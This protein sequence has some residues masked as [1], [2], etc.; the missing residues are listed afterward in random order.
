LCQKY[1]ASSHKFLVQEACTTNTADNNTINDASQKHS[2]PI[3]P[4]NF[5]HVFE[6]NEAVSYSV[7][8]NCARKKLRKKASHTLKKIVLKFLE[9]VSLLSQLKA[10]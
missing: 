10:A 2:Q 4:H 6:R 7:Q 3:K 1:N 8:E 5:G 9:C